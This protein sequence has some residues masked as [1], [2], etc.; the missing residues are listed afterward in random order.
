M[1]KQKQHNVEAIYALSPMQ[2]GMLFHSLY[3][4]TSG[5]YF[6]QLTCTLSGKLNPE[7]L[8]Q[9]WQEIVDRH[10]VLRTLFI[11]QH[12]KEPVQVVRQHVSLPWLSLDWRALAP[13]LQPEQLAEFLA[14]D[15]A[16]G[17][18][19][20]HAPLMRLALIRI[21]DETYHFV[22]SFHHL[23]L[24]GWSMPLVIKEVFTFYEG[25]SQGRAVELK[26]VRPYR[27]YIRWLREQDMG[28]AEQFWREMLKS[29]SSPTAL[30]IERHIEALERSE[31]TKDRFVEHHVR[32]TA[33]ATEE[34]QQLA[35]THQVTLNTVVQGAWALLLSHYSGSSDVVFGATVSGR[36]ASLPGVE[37]MVGLFINTLPVRVSVK[38]AGGVG[39]YLRRLQ[40]QQVEVRQYEYSPLA[41]VQRWSEVPQG[42]PLF[43]TL[44]AFENYPVGEALGER[45]AGLEVSDIRNTERNSYP[46]ALVAAPSRELAIKAV[47]DGWKYSAETIRRMMGHL[48][49]LLQGIVERPEAPLA[50]LPLLTPAERE[51]ILVAWNETTA[52]YPLSSCIQ[53]LFEAQVHRSPA[54]VAVRSA[55]ASLTFA[56]LEARANQLA[57]YLLESGIHLQSVV[58]LL[59]DHSCETLIAILGVL[60]AG[61]A[62]LPLDPSHPAAR[63][64]FALA[65]AEAALLITTQSLQARLAAGLPTSPA[66]FA[67]DRDWERCAAQPATAP[68]LPSLSSSAAAYLIYTSGS[69]GIPKGVVIEHA[70][71]V[72]Y[73]CWAQS[74]YPTADCALYSSLAFDLTVTS[75]FL[76]L[77]S[78]NT[79]H[80]YPPPETGP[81]LLEVLADNRC[82]VLK[83]TPSHLALIRDRDNRQSVIRCL[84]VGGEALSSELAQAVSASFGH[85]V[86][87]YNEYGPTEATVGCMLYRF[88]PESAERA[89]VPI[90]RPAGNT[91]IYILDE[92]LAPTAEHVTGELY[93]GGA[94]VARGYLGRAELTAERFVPDPF[95]GRAGGRLYRTGDRARRLADGEL[96]YLGRGDEQVKYHGY[97]VELNELRLALS[98]HARVRDAVVVLR[99]DGA[100]GREQLV[101]YYVGREAVAAEELRQHMQERVIAETVPQWYVHLRRLPLTLNGKVNVEALPAPW[102]EEQCDSKEGNGEPRTEAEQ[103]LVTIWREVLGCERIRIDDNFFELGGHS[104]L[105]TQVISRVQQCF[106]VELPLRVLFATRTVA[107]LAEHLKE[108]AHK[109]QDLLNAPPPISR[110]ARGDNPKLSFA[111]KRLWFL[112]RMDSASTSYN[113]ASA[114]WLKGPLDV[115]SLDRTFSEIVRRHEALRTTFAVVGTEPVQIIGEPVVHTLPVVDLAHLPASERRAETERRAEAEAARPFDLESGPLMRLQLLRLSPEE[116]ALLVTMHHIVSD[117]WSIG[118]LIKEVAALYAAYVRGEES[119]LAELP[120]QYADFAHWQRNW[121]QG[122]V[123][124][125]QFDY[126]RAELAGSPA[127]INLPLDRPRLKT[128]EHHAATHSFEIP[129]GLVNALKQLGQERDATLFMVLHAAF[130]SLLHYHTGEVDIVIGTDV[131]NRNKVELEGLIGFFVNQLVLRT[132]VS[133]DPTFEELLGRVRKVAL[134]AYAHQHLPFDALVEM[135]NPE[136]SMLHSPVFQVKLVLVNTPLPPLELSGLSLSLLEVEPKTA[137]FDLMFTLREDET[138]LKCKVEYS[139]G[140]FDPATITRMV[141]GFVKIPGHIAGYPT[142]RLSEISKLLA[143]L[144][145]QTQSMLQA[146]F[147]GM[148]RDKLKSL[149]PKPIV[150]PQSQSQTN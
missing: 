83:L 29:F 17:F 97:R 36:P 115:A 142:A 3:T 27:E 11:W 21:A 88:H 95:S 20:Q 80:L 38:S 125:A 40:A 7:A 117:G 73:I 130:L 121:L 43:E 98:A 100:N 57:H 48:E 19:L 86:E 119:P 144:D 25:L 101:G 102:L 87:I 50:E 129:A 60:K 23:L 112:Q 51:Q 53:Q 90:G 111:Q 34:L 24:D 81:A 66:V 10:S 44:M 105:A 93:I 134:G 123:L 145:T 15:L 133:G 1:S 32:L 94:G 84:I 150:S 63:M 14:A 76:P 122:A 124:S 61:C 77:V 46:L 26:A 35:R 131:A 92:R 139:T 106:Q 4:P 22:W 5:E 74:V 55:S 126:W 68:S 78:G 104:L 120:V 69:T 71:L 138:G 132:D 136:R 99:K 8:H 67:M 2:Q 49:V 37:E 41:E 59:L 31:D 72:N 42:T 89:W 47:Y 79:L 28:A 91:Q 85:Q 65:D 12:R 82:E 127:L 58:A 141:E 13:A 118:V 148:R 137:K 30:G 135:L 45:S 108:I 62:Y 116:H 9:A 143:D 54:A 64:A 6:V 146:E 18:D 107:E 149:V 16:T 114:V 33:E 56:E 113:I 140:L 75:L 52:E 128:T 147:K 110:N 109:K 96:E 70:S 103:Q 39:D